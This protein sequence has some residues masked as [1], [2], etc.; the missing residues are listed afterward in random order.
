MV[1]LRIIYVTRNIISSPNNEQVKP[2][3]DIIADDTVIFVWPKPSC[4]TLI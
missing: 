3:N 2:L 1:Q 4:K